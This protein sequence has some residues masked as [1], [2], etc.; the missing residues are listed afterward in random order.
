MKFWPLNLIVMTLW[1]LIQVHSTI[2]DLDSWTFNKTIQ[3]FPYSFVKFDTNSAEFGP[4]QKVFKQLASNV[5]N[6]NDLLMAQVNVLPENMDLATRFQLTEKAYLPEFILFQKSAK[7]NSNFEVVTRYGAQFDLANLVRFLKI[8]TGL[9]IG[10][11]GCLQDLDELA[12]VFFRNSGKDRQK[13]MRQV[14]DILLEMQ[15]TRSGNGNDVISARK[16]L[17]IM[18]SLVQNG[19]DFIWKEEQRLQKIL[20]NSKMSEQKAQDLDKSLNILKSFQ[21]KRVGFGKNIDEL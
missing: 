21:W 6:Q 14:S 7:Q 18:E 8:K 12:A 17:K 1:P 10:L 16:Y 20:Q 4:K 2:L 9:Y 15:K 3:A 13:I 5:L 11:P 19:D